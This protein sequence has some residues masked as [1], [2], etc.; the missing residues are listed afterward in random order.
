MTVTGDEPEFVLGTAQLGNDYGI[1]RHRSGAP[2]AEAPRDF[3]A[4]ARDLGVDM[5][6]TAPAYGRAEAIIGEAAWSGRIHT[7]V[8]RGAEPRNSVERSLDLLRREKVDVLYLHDPATVLDSTALL[9]TA[10]HELVGSLVRRLGASIYDDAEFEAA[11]RDDR[12]GAVQIPCNVLDRRFSADRLSAAVSAGMEIYVRSA[13]LQGVLA[14]PTSELPDHL[15]DLR[16]YVDAFQTLASQFGRSPLEAALAWAR[17]LPGVR[18]VIVGTSSATELRE[19]LAAFRAEPLTPVE[20][21]RLDDLP[22][23]RP[24][25]TDPRT[26]SVTP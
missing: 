2:H 15:G 12:I 13:L 23:P 6:D 3:L 11:L 10:A 17:S 16:P 20:L 9:L 7:K 8:S 5:L 22:T 18:G 14:M 26:W 25:L 21:D 4:A 19:L 1:T 24:Q